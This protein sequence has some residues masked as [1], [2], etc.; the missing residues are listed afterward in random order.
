ML[1]APCQRR[2]DP[3]ILTAQPV[4][5]LHGECVG[6]GR[7]LALG[8]TVRLLARVAAVHDQF[9]ETFEVFDQ[10]DPERGGN[11]P[12]FA[13]RQRLHLLVV[14]TKRHSTAASKWLSVCATKA[15]ATPNTR[16]Y[17]RNEHRQAKNLSTAPPF[18]TVLLRLHA[19]SNGAGRRPALKMIVGSSS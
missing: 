12:E 10:H 13:D 11:R 2:G 15:R 6:Q 16:G 14:R 19:S 4:Y 18:G 1:V 9:A 5:E 7:A 17:P 8:E 3:R